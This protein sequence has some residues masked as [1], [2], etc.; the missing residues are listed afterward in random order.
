MMETV[1]VDRLKRAL[2]HVT[3]YPEEWNQEHW[4]YALVTPNGDVCQTACCLAGRVLAN[5][6]YKFV[7]EGFEARPSYVTAFHARNGDKVNI[8]QRAT[9]LLGLT[10]NDAG[11]LF[12]PGN[13]LDELWQ[14]A[15]ELTDG[16]I[17]LPDGYDSNYLVTPIEGD[18]FTPGLNGVRWYAPLV[19]E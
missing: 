15:R 17:V 13:S 4:A 7:W 12:D 8:E 9:E 10:Y 5:E 14:I 6:G 3:A 11:G 2:L 19:L 1:E 16:K 18:P